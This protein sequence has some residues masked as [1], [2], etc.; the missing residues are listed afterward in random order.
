MT[1]HPLANSN[2]K[3][4]WLSQALSQ[5]TINL[6]N[7]LLLARIFEVTKSS[8]AVSL[9]WLSYSLP[10]L[11]LA[12]FSGPIV[13]S[14]SKRKLM[15]MALL[16]QAVVISL[17]FVNS[18]HHFLPYALVFLYSFLD[19]LY[20]PSLQSAIPS[21][22]AKSQ[23]PTA[24]SLFVLTSQ[25]SFLFGFGLGGFFLTLFSPNIVVFMSL[26]L[27]LVSAYSVYLL[28]KDSS[29]KGI[30][31][32]TL[33]EFLQDFSSGV[34]YLSQVPAL[35][36]PIITIIVAQ[37]AITILSVILPSYSQSV[38]KISLS[39]ASLILILPG[40]L[41]AI[42]FSHFLPD[43]LKTTRKLKLAEAGFLIAAISLFLLSS[44][45]TFPILKIA[46]AI[47]VAIGFGIAFSALTIPA[48]T[49][50]QSASSPKFIG[51][52]YGSLT[53][54]LILATYIP[55]LLAAV[56]SDLFGV[57]TLIFVFAILATA[58]FLFIRYKGN[59][60]MANGFRF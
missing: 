10:A 48:H 34:S 45:G 47:L 52:V 37:I 25:A 44:I 40:A 16:F 49:L 11:F 22:V 57:T 51:R 23:L 12:P 59:Y 20:L 1:D 15:I 19:Q 9:L 26:I 28:P 36:L 24:N 8:I 46:I 33:Y 18:S 4:L 56:I 32:K 55:L 60:V 27:L 14:V 6:V 7:F 58:C 43:L 42:A 54:L 5:L 41:G 35:Y 21:V 2:F 39:Q 53:F 17:L 3:K 50:I 38:L 13:D 30:S 31:K 29:S